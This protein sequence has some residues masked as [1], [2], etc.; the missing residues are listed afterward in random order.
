VGGVMVITDA[1][2]NLL[3]DGQG[4]TYTWDVRGRLTVIK[5]NGV[6]TATF[7]Y[8]TDGIRTSEIGNQE[9]QKLSVTSGPP[10]AS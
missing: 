10:R 2:G 8:N 1:N 6:A 3:D 7:L 9:I 4:N 5:H